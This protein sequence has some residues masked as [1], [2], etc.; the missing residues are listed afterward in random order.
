MA[1]MD[2][3]ICEG[4][5]RFLINK[6]LG[7][8]YGRYDF[9]NF[10]IQNIIPEKEQPG[11]WEFFRSQNMYDH[12]TLLPGAYDVI[13]KWNERYTFFIGTSFIYPQIEWDSGFLVDQKMQFFRRELPFLDPKKM[14]FGWYKETF[15][16]DV[17]FDDKAANLSGAKLKLLMDA[18][19]NRDIDDK[20]LKR[21]RIKRC[22][23]WYDADKKIYKYER[24]SLIWN[25]EKN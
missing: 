13:K 25:R 16:F 3:V 14:D 15:K 7:T 4:G 20:T 1:D 22:V 19:H 5:F 24:K 17:K 18:Y 10:Y 12:C 11:F 8:N 2:D 9:K 21:Q 6:Y 23:D